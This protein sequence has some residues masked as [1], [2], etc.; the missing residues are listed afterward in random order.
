MNDIPD[1]Q[2]SERSLTLMRAR[3]RI[4]ANATALQILQ[5]ATTVLAP[6]I[7]AIVA[8]NVPAWR[9]QLAATS[10]LLLL[11][12]ILFLDRLQA[13]LLRQAAKVAE[14]FDCE[15]L[16]LAW[17][18]FVA[19]AKLDW[20][21]I[22]GAAAAYPKNEKA[23]AAIRDWYPP[24]VGRAPLHVA[25][26]IC[27]LTN[28]RYDTK[29]RERWAAILV[30]LPFLAVVAGFA[31]WATMGLTLAAVVLSIFVPA[32]P[33][34]VWA[35]RETFRHRDAAR[36]QKAIKGAAETLWPSI[37]ERRE[38][39]CTNRAREFQDAIYQ[40]RALSPLVFPLVYHL[41]RDE[42]EEQMH[43]GAEERL[44]EAGY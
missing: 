36:A 41:L 17:N 43:K 35:L 3:Q 11:I 20:E 34:V 19:G 23:L 8:L 9:A 27:Q 32:T 12:D 29:L 14:Q 30:A 40:R 31:A 18:A 37:R 38:T 26:I 2:N 33:I 7:L 5:L 21:D 25:R 28:M 13:R 42:M 10:L 1:Q 22:Q 16:Q 6:T 15:V 44:N 4:Y 39:E 24:V